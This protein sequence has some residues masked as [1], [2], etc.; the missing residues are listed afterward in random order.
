MWWRWQK[1]QGGGRGARGGIGE[2]CCSG[3]HQ[4]NKVAGCNEG[5]AVL[6][7][8]G[9]GATVVAVARKRELEAAAAAGEAKNGVVVKMEAVLVVAAA[10]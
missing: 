2:D 9:G 3:R 5:D 4:D 7:L 10:C 6:T 1:Q 8:C